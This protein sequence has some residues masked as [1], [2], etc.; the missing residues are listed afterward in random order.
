[1][2]QLTRTE[3][4]GAFQKFNSHRSP[5]HRYASYDYCFNY[6]HSFHNKE[7]IAFPQNLEKSCLVLGYYLASWGM[8]RGKSFIS[9]NSI[10]NYIS[11]IK[12]IA[13]DCSK[14]VWKIDINLYNEKNIG[15]LRE[16]RKST[17]LNSS[18]LG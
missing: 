14:D 13:N 17:R 3:I 5:G 9:Q 16:D 10:R 11:I 1:M 2:P 18:H 6:F 7:E 8:H 12:W 4:R 15:I